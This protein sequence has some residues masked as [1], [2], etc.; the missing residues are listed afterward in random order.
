MNV[1]LG[2]VKLTTCPSF[3][4]CAA[5]AAFTFGGAAGIETEKISEADKPLVSVAV[6]FI[7]RFDAV[8][9][10]VPVNVP[11]FGLNASQDGKGAPFESVALYVRVS[12]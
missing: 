2:N 3:Q 7:L 4:V 12:S 11:V 6:N 9:G 5:V 10:T 1:L 8:V